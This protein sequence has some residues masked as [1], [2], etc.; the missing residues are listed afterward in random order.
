VDELDDFLKSAPADTPAAP[1]DSPDPNDEPLPPFDNPRPLRWA[2]PALAL[3]LTG[4]LVWQQRA[5][6]SYLVASPTPVDLGGPTEFHLERAR[7]AVYARI[8]G[9]S[10]SE[11]SSYR[12][13]LLNRELV[14][15]VDVP[16]IID[17]P[18][19]SG[20]RLP[21]RL[22]A[23]GRIEPEVRRLQLTDV[24]RYFL[25]HDDLSPPGEKAGTSHVW[26]IADGERPRALG[27]N[28]AWCALLVALGAFNVAWLYRRLVR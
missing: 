28:A 27:W 12:K 14:P 18:R 26:I 19:S 10:A 24:I 9:Q 6:F 25:L 17:R 13:G 15:L 7:K 22:S 5:D 11:S 23:E 3:T 4:A 16:V 2:I 8:E 1:P 20:S 21:E